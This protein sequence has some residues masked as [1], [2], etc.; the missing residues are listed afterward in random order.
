MAGTRQSDVL[1]DLD[2]ERPHEPFVAQV[3]GRPV[4]F[5]P[6]T[7]P[8]WR[9][10]LVALDD[11]PLFIE[12]FGPRKP[13]KVALVEQLPSWKM[14]ALVRAWRKHH[15]LCPTDK[16]HRRLVAMLAK[17]EYRAA[18]ERDLSEVHHRDL[19][20]EWQARRWRRL[21]NDIDG[22]DRTSHLHEVMSQ[23]DELAEAVLEGE[24]KGDD[25][26]PRRSMREFDAQ[27][28]VLSTIADRMGELIVVTGL[29]KGIK[30]RRVPPMPRPQTAYQR[31]REKWVKR[32]HN[33]TVARVYGYVDAKGKPTGK[34][35][36]GGTPPTS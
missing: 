31:A 8:P 26:P 3:A 22:L 19:T 18:I 15:G 7:G 30:A 1:D 5:R 9:E 14:R 16:G 35:P 34:Q 28:E 13:R 6:A 4:A 32:K 23:D 17:A 36:A 12:L 27:V 2:A 33:Y 21:L 25:N 10:L 20:E 29:T 11:W 24:S